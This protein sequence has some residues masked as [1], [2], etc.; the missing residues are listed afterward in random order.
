MFEDHKKVGKKLVPMFGQQW[1]RVD[2]VEVILPE[3]I[4][5]GFVLERHGP[6][7][8][9]ELAIVL[10]EAAFQSA[11]DQPQPEFSFISAHRQLSDDGKAAVREKLRSARKLDELRTA[12]DPFVRCYPKDNPL[13]YLWDAAIP[14]HSDAD[15]ATARKVVG[16]RLNR[17]SPE[18]TLM[19]AAVL[20]GEHATGR[21]KYSDNV[22]P[23]NLEAIVSDFDS[24]EGQHASS[25]ARTSTSMVYAHYKD[26]LGNAWAEYFWRRGLALDPL[27]SHIRLPKVPP[28]N[29]N[30]VIAFRQGFHHLAAT[31]VKEVSEQVISK[32]VSE[33]EHTVINALVARQATLA[34][35]L[36]DN[37]E[38]WNWDIGPLYLRAMTD[39]YITLAW[40]LGKPD[41]RSR[42]HILHG[43]GQEKLWMAHYERLAE[44]EKDEEDKERYR[45]MIEASRTWVESQSFLFFVTVNLGNWAGKTTREM[46]VEAGCLDLYNFAYTPYSFSAHNT[47]NHLGKFNALPSRSPLHK[48]MRMPHIPHFSGEPSVMMNAAKYLDMAIAAV[49]R[50]YGLSVQAQPSYTWSASRIGDVCEFLHERYG[51]SGKA[52][53]TSEKSAAPTE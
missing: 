3:I 7:K 32:E 48:N 26:R 14:S 17:W 31:L 37:F 20:Y 9:I 28:K 44:E 25:H 33:E 10:I 27:R 18:G 39:C 46:A 1:S 29:E 42:L 12:L 21:L 16:P 51:K 36:A 22:K 53:K 38:V 8:G 23:P 13:A 15:V 30:P 52:S 11:T 40:I 47:W 2:F 6:Q 50:T 49:A 19:Q 5:I 41:E 4:W 43:L 24:P 45:L 34:V 35:A